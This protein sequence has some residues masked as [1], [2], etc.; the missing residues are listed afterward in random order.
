MDIIG[1]LWIIW[2]I[3]W[4]AAAFAVKPTQRREA[5]ASRLIVSLAMLAGAVLLGVPRSLGHAF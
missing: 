3:V 4:I 2:L 5:A 1:A